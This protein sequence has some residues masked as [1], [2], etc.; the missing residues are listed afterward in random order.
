VRAARLMGWTARRGRIAYVMTAAGAE[1][2]DMR[3]ASALDYGHYIERQILPIAAS[4]ADA[5]GLD[6]RLWL[7]EA[8]QKELDFGT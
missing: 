8:S 3:S 5:V 6:A 7:D 4:I 1:P 2:I